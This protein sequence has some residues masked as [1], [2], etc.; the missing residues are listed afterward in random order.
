MPK[1]NLMNDDQWDLV[2]VIT[3]EVWKLLESRQNDVTEMELFNAIRRGVN[4]FEKDD[5]APIVETM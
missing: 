1:L 4:R 2:D 5:L 3:T